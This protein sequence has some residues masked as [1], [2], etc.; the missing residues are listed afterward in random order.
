MGLQNPRQRKGTHGHSLPDGSA[1]LFDANRKTV[2]PMN[3]SAFVLWV[4]CDGSHSS[5]D[6]VEHMSVVFD[7]PRDLIV[8][9]VNATLECL[10]ELDLLERTA[11]TELS[12]RACE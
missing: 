4:C 1:I 9:D 12:C 7:A 5:A 8:R 3:A 11:E 10:R 2:Y 6:I